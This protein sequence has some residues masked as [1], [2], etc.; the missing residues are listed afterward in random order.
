MVH[1]PT[2]FYLFRYLN[3]RNINLTEVFNQEQ[4]AIRQDIDSLFKHLKHNIEKQIR[5]WWDIATIEMY[6]TE[7]ITPRRLR[8]DISPN[9]AVN[10]KGLMEDWYKFFNDSENALL[11]KIVIRRRHKLKNIE[12]EILQIR[13]QLVPF[14][15]SREYKEKENKL[16]EA[17]T[18][19]DKEIQLKK[20]KKFRRDVLDYKNQQVYKWQIDENYMEDNHNISMI[21]ESRESSV[22]EDTTPWQEIRPT[23]IRTPRT[24]PEE[25]PN[26]RMRREGT[27]P[28]RRYYRDQAGDENRPQQWNNPSSILRTPR[29]NNRYSPLRNEQHYT[30]YEEPSHRRGFFPREYRGRPPVFRNRRSPYR[31]T[32]GP[33]DRQRGGQPFRL[34]TRNRNNGDPRRSWNMRTTRNTYMG[35]RNRMQEE[36]QREERTEH[37]YRPQRWERGEEHAVREEESRRKRRREY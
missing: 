34:P 1:I 16:Q 23:E 36:T 10:D 22:I 33:Q 26:I 6:I 30:P 21:D 9:D 37:T 4:V 5:V 2:S 17:M 8:W 15:E 18:K 32:Y 13:D 14:L 28:E 12:T 7:K 25:L 19:Y 29:Y 20:Q 11:G 35:P 27:S 31:D 3:N 24:R